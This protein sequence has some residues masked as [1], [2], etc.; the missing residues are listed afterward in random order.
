MVWQIKHALLLYLEW[1]GFRRI[2]RIMSKI[3]GKHYRHQTIMN[4][5][6]KA[7]LEVLKEKSKQEKVEVSE[8]NKSID[9][10]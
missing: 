8:M 3:F 10:C 5:I 7:G 4:W 1:G 9:C 2:A 6:K